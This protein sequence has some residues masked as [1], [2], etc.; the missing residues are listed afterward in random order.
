MLATRLSLFFLSAFM[1][2]FSFSPPPNDRREFGVFYQARGRGR[3]PRDF[4]ANFSS[5]PLSF[6]LFSSF[7]FSSF[8]A[9]PIFCRLPAAFN[10]FPCAAGTMHGEPIAAPPFRSR[11]IFNGTGILAIARACTRQRIVNPVLSARSYNPHVDLVIPRVPL[12]LPCLGARQTLD[13]WS[14][15]TVLHVFRT[16]TGHFFAMGGLGYVSLLP[17]NVLHIDL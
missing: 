3:S 15:M 9:A 4:F 11:L 12:V 8:F 1:L 17:S 5:F 2:P 10:F 6:F 16:S 7:S 13:I 14:K